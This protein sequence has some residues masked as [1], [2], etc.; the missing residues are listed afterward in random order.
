MCVLIDK[1]ILTIIY[2]Y[3][4]NFVVTQSA[5]SIDS[6]IFLSTEFVRG[7][8]LIF[9]YMKK[10]ISVLFLGVL[11]ACSLNSCSNDNEE[12]TSLKFALVGAW[13]TSME[14]SNW[15]SINIEPNGTMKY[16]YMSKEELEQEGYVYDEEEGVYDLIEGMYH[17]VYNPQSNAYW[18]FD[19]TSQSIS[20]YTESGYYAFTYKV[21]MNNDLKSWVGIDSTGKTYTFVKKE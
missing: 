9:I 10:I 3:L 17:I 19:E 2:C 14:S 5:V 20:M 16:G 12:A 15:K 18:A 6:H 21:V 1:N 13:K 7:T 4:F 8:S 11:V